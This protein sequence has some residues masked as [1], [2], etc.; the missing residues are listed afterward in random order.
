LGTAILCLLQLPFL[1][2]A[3]TLLIQY[4][5]IEGITPMRIGGLVYAVVSLT[6]LFS[7]SI[8]AFVQIRKTGDTNQRLYVT[9]DCRA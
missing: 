8:W 3:T 7:V 2:S 5:R 1:I 9:P 6:A 4:I